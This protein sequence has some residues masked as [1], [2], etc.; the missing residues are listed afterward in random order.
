MDAPVPPTRARRPLKLALP[1]H[2]LLTAGFLALTAALLYLMARLLIPFLSALL[3]AAVVTL[4]V[5]PVYRWLERAFG[6]RPTAAALITTLL[7][8][9]AVIGPLGLLIADLARESQ[10]AFEGLK[11]A[12]QDERLQHLMNRLAALPAELF[13][14]LLSDA[15]RADLEER[16]RH[17]VPGL[18]GSAVAGLSRGLS[19]GIAN[20]SKFVVDLFVVLVAVFYFLREGERWLARLGETVPLSPQVWR[21]VTEKFS[22]TL[23]AVV[24]GMLVAAAVLGVLLAAGFKWFG[25]PLPAFLGM[26][27]FFF[28]PVPFIGAIAIWAPACLWLWAIAGA[29]DRALGLAAY[30]AVAIFGVDNFL[31]PWLIGSIARLP[32]LFMLLSILGGLVAYGPLGIFLGPVLLAITLAV[33]G[34]FRDVSRRNGAPARAVR[35]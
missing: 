26:L 21:I 16:I 12:M 22:T 6:A 27:A 23:R 32:V 31:R 20:A 24:H 3:W 18:A 7:V 10:A 2:A 8:L 33:G 25:V 19:R 4:V 14:G 28:A 15:E 30:G 13:P 11:R 9:A 1:P 17:L 34:I 29:P 35:S 5:Y